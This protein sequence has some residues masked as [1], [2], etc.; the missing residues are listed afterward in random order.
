VIGWDKLEATLAEVRIRI[1]QNA[2][3]L[4]DKD[5]NQRNKS[6]FKRAKLELSHD[7]NPKPSIRPCPLP[8]GA[9]NTTF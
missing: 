7:Q 3:V 4:Q 6:P 8:P 1:N 5:L 9:G 2:E